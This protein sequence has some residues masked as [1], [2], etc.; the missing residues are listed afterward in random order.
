MLYVGTNQGLYYKPKNSNDPL[1]LVA[2]LDGQVWSLQILNNSLLCGHDKGAF[3]II[4]SKAKPLYRGAGVWLFRELNDNQLLAGTYNGLHLFEKTSDDL[5]YS[6]HIQDF[7]MSSRY[8]E[9]INTHELLVS[10]EYKGVFKL[11]LDDKNNAA[12]TVSSIPDVPTSLYSSMISFQGD[13]CYF[14]KDGFFE[15]EPETNQFVKNELIS[16]LF[17][18]NNFTSAKMVVDREK[19]LWLFERNNLIRAEKGA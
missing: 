11:L 1:K 9:L 7:S 15:Y 13:I 5:R 8:F 3:Q 12:L 4:G 18:E 17:Q 14:S 2:G 16:S 19:Y 6:H 10:H